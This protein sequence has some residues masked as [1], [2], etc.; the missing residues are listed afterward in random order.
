MPP[1]AIELWS[2]RHP[3]LF[4][5]GI[6]VAVLLLVASSIFF[7]YGSV[8]R[9][10]SVGP[11]RHASGFMDYMP[12][13]IDPCPSHYRCGATTREQV[14]MENNLFS[15][16]REGS[17]YTLPETVTSDQYDVV[18]TEAEPPSCMLDRANKPGADAREEEGTYTPY[19]EIENGYMNRASK[20][21]TTAASLVSK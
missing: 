12:T 14:R 20:H 11:P 3:K 10:M 7:K 5:G 1:N 16:L 19:D 2:K 13:A 4:V 21:A 18:A 8:I 6:V 17:K 9:T 15:D